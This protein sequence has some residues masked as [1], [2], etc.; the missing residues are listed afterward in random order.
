[1][2]INIMC[3]K[4]VKQMLHESDRNQE[5]P[6]EYATVVFCRYS[7]FTNP[8]HPNLARLLRYTTSC[9]MFSP[10]LID[11]TCMLEE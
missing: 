9:K 6:L 8:I 7:S 4:E 2:L 3:Q 5:C 1:M 11:S 10:V